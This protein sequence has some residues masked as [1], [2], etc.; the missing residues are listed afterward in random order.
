MPLSFFSDFSL[1]RV[2]WPQ[3]EE[4]LFGAELGEE[5]EEVKEKKER[6]RG[7]RGNRRTDWHK[8]ES[9]PTI[10]F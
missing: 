10:I 4:P 9:Y 8:G 3:Q 7:G 1:L 5:E 6:Q 2:I